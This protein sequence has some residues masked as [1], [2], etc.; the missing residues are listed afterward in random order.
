MWRNTI[1]HALN[2]LCSDKTWRFDHS[3]PVEGP[4]YITI[5]D[6]IQLSSALQDVQ[7][8]PNYFHRKISV[9]NGR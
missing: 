5:F 4:I 9:M 2:V 7:F 1:K 6:N 3:K 8:S